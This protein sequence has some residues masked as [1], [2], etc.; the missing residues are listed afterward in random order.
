MQRLILLAFMIFTVESY[1]QN[2]PG[3]MYYSTDGKIL[4]TGGRA[5]EGMYDKNVI[6]KVYLD[7]TQSDYW[8]QLEDNYESET[9]IPASMTIDGIVYDSVGVRFRGNTSYTMIGDSPKKSFAIST[10]LIH[11]DQLVMGFKNFKFNNAHQDASFMREVLY[12]QMASRHTPIAKANYIEL[13]L[14]DEY[15][16][17][18]P[19]IQSVDKIFLEGYFLSNDGARFRATTEETGPGGGGGGPGWGDGTA[20]MNYL[21]GDTSTYQ[22]YYDLKSSD[23]DDSWQKL[24]AACE[25][26]STTTVS[27]MDAVRAKIDIDKALWFLAVEN[28]F[29]DDDSYIMKGKMDY[30]VYYEPETDRTTP[31]E[32][33]GNS[34]FLSNAATSWG[35]FKNVTN[36]NYPLLNKLLNI[37]EWRQRYLAHYRTIL[38]ETFTTDNANALIDSLN[39]QINAKVSSDPKKLYTYNQYTN[40]I[41]GLKTF[42]ANRR[43]FL[44]N[45]TEVAQLAPTILAAPYFNSAFEENKPPV[46][47]ETAYVQ[48]NITSSNVISKVNLYYATGLVGNFTLTQMFDDG[49]HGDEENGDGIYGAAIPGFNTGTTVRYYIEAKAD[50]ASLSAAYLPTG[51]EHD[52]YVYTVAESVEPNGVVINEILASNDTGETDEA[53]ENEDWVELYNTNDFEVDLSG[54]YMTDDASELNKWQMPSGTV[55]PAN[56]YLIIWADEDLDQGPLHGD[57]KLSAGGEVVILSDTLLDIVEQVSFGAQ[58]TDLGY[59]RFPNGTGEFRI[60]EATFNASNNINQVTSGVVI[61]EILASNDTGATDEAGDQEDWVEL[62][63]NNNYEVDLSGFYLTDDGAELNK[64]SFP[65]GTVIAA[66][67]YLIIWAD[68]EAAEGPLHSSWKLSAGGESVTL[69]DTAL[70]ILD[71]VTFGAQTTDLGFARVPNGTGPFAIQQAT[72]NASNN[73]QPITS[74]IVVNE[75]LASN[76]TGSTDEAGDFEDWI[77]LY[78][79]NDFEVDLSGFYL[80]DDTTSLQKWTFPAGSIISPNSYMIIWA[81]DEADE[82][83][84]HAAFKLS[85]GGEAVVLSDTLL[86]IL[87]RIVYPAQTSDFGYARV[88]NGTGPFV[89]QEPTF[90]GNNEIP[91]STSEWLSA[92]DLAIFPNPFEHQITIQLQELINEI[93][94]RIIDQFG[95]SIQNGL[96]TGLTTTLDLKEWPAGVYYFMTGEATPVYKKIIKL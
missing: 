72:F 30:Y 28:V 40:G 95:R 24:V 12:C 15:W 6:R 48:A 73:I 21:G 47:D 91:S 70:N 18:Y 74:G 31:L 1:A 33:D 39:A 63:N 79:L 54:F 68:D 61:N 10:D 56:G 9:E 4:F 88:P 75:I 37:P 78:N 20:G 51:A 55:I 94:Y 41:A 16:G 2:L 64:W 3:E 87:E 77:E 57:F 65:V 82:G 86:N 62:Y 19:N 35:P 26:L 25:A 45:N 46:T 93:P 66:N 52:V 85:G 67:D 29:A 43:T 23:I 32:Y 14:N 44:L 96:I 38:N 13:Y 59:A 7:F 27:T 80:S 5:P 69:A 34:S 11:E 58:T 83:S 60:Q 76:N 8:E 71:S 42:V 90:N 50:N 53:G 92:E 81:D 89:I 17:L 36:A 84:F 49:A 22:E